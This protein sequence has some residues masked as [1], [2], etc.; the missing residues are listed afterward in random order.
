MSTAAE[1]ILAEAS[2]L[3]DS[4][5]ASDALPL[6]QRARL[7]HPD[8]DGIALR[9]ADALQLVGKLPEAVRAYDS[10][11]R[12][13][14]NS[15]EGWYGLGCA[16]LELKAYGAA[17]IAFG[18]TIERAP[19]F[20]AAQYNLAKAAFQLGR[21]ETAIE[22]F[23][24]AAAVD[25]ALK[26][27]ASASIACIIPGSSE[28]GLPAVLR[29]RKRWA[30]AET[31]GLPKPRRPAPEPNA[32]RKL[33][34]GYLSAFFGDRNWMKPVYALLNRHDR[35]AFE[36]HLFSDGTLPDAASGYREHDD[37]IIHDLRGVPNEA[38]A[39]IV[40]GR[41]LDVL[42]DLNG[43]GVQKRLGLLMRRP[44]PQ[45]V[46]WF[47][48]F[49]ATGLDAIDWLVGDAAVIPKPEEKHY[50][51]RIHRVPG[52][53]LPFEILY[54]VPDVAPPPSAAAGAPITF[55]CLGSH[56]KLTDAT[57]A[58]WA[59]ILRAAPASRLFVK[60]GALEDGS[61]RDDLLGRLDQSGIAPARVTLAGRSEHFAF[62]DAY[63]QVDIALDTFPYNG[64]TTTTEALWQGVPVL[65]F[66][67]DRWV[68]RTS[69]SLLLAGGLGDWVMPDAAAYVR[70]AV[71][72]ALDPATPTRLAAL[73][74]GMR[75]RLAA[76]AACDADGFCREM[77]TFY[78][79][80]AAARR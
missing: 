46:G 35:A 68:G 27:Q 20:G 12:L 23:E 45:I 73:R 62:L 79:S 11:L 4:G 9:L 13:V 49:A 8:H 50:G 74:S 51:E 64:G 78:R 22:L 18:R 65:A 5:A 76:S 56:Y 44:A 36:I 7:L 32:G 66:D 53:Y 31:R 2:A 29:A 33:R 47:N 19:G 21:V 30:E 40:A 72:L 41:R 80:L 34:L 71:E 54:P 24:R 52:T 26:Q 70:R 57:L 1:T 3:L 48:S 59:E 14:P 63:A 6:L 28:A 16:Q 42:I 75:A 69:K 39:D 43:Y 55:G 61:T 37:D 17:A 67:G 77:E 25:P 10:A 58:A 38:A 15:V 60:N